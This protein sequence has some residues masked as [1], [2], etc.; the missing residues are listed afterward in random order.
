MSDELL[1][2]AEIARR[3][4]VHRATVGDWIASNQLVAAQTVKRGKAE[5]KLFS[6]QAAQPLIDEALTKARAREST[7]ENV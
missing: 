6:A 7:P 4:G 2:A 3:A 5:Q 1:T